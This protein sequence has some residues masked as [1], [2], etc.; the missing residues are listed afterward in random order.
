MAIIR[1]PLQCTSCRAIT[2]T[3]T[4][5]GLF[6]PNEHRFPCPGCGVEI[7][8]TLKRSK[9]RRVGYSFTRP[10]NGRWVKSEKGAVAT[11][12]FDPDRVAPKDMTNVFS[13]F[14][15]ESMKLT[16]TARAF[17][18][19]E[20]GLRRNWRDS[21]WPWI[22]KLIVHFDN[23]NLSL[24][25]KEAKVRKGSPPA[26]SW[27]TRLALL[28]SVFE[29]AFDNFTLNTRSAV[30]RVRARVVLAQSKEPGLFDELVSQ[31]RSSGRML[32]TWQELNKARTLFLASYLTLSP[33]LGTQYW[34]PPARD[35]D[36]FSLPDKRFDQLRQ[37]YVDS[38]ETLCRLTVVAIALEATIQHQKLALPTSKGHMT[39]WQYE[40]LPHGLKHT[41]LTRYPIQ[42]LFVPYMDSRLR[43]GLG[44]A[45]AFYDSG[46]DE[47]VYYTQ[48]DA[49]LVETR[50]PYAT[51]GF[52]ALEMFSA[53]ELGAYYFHALHLRGV[54]QE[55]EEA[56]S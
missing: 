6:P 38:F 54:E 52:R 39:L 30:E 51:F 23:Q 27:V 9:N 13:P 10:V 17:Y 18:A 34:R 33:I 24:F 14:L 1:S 36:G 20:E 42:D 5:P 31:Y 7:R 22:E 26:A 15:D 47:V 55:T 11:L 3:R 8:Y 50:L 48:D 46:R 32:K 49:A 28:Y 2:I 12:T 29:G 25:D 19:R 35:F 44:H 53:M 16:P 56:S 45:R 37:L 41:Q 43:N 4:A 21:Q 40:A